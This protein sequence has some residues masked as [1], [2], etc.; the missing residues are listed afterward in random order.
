MDKEATKW[1]IIIGIQMR[2]PRHCQ[3]LKCHTSVMAGMSGARRGT[4]KQIQW[5]SSLGIWTGNLMGTHSL[6][7][8]THLA[9]CLHHSNVCLSFCAVGIVLVPPPKK[10]KSTIDSQKRK[11]RN[12]LPQSQFFLSAD[13]G[14]ALSYTFIFLFGE[15]NLET[16]WPYV[17]RFKPPTSCFLHLEH[18]VA[19]SNQ[20]MVEWVLLF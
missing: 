4:K 12:F 18:N 9:S 16:Q 11:K 3:G 15:L 6:L 10:K 5:S 14:D 7:T 2:S 20:W 13:S 1:V 19:P 17:R 8:P